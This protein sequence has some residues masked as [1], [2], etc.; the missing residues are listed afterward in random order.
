MDVAG[1]DV[2][3][4]DVAGCGLCGVAHVDAAVGAAAAL[5]VAAH[6]AATHATTHI[7]THV[8]ARLGCIVRRPPRVLRTE[9]CAS[10]GIR[11]LVHLPPLRRARR[12]IPAR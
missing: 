2:A 9:V 4:M 3:G 7:A 8:A 12:T 6:V 1:M 10:L 11:E 5:H